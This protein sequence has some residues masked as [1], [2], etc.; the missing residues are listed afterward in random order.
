MVLK[1]K[2]IRLPRVLVDLGPCVEIHLESGKV[3]RPGRKSIHL[4]SNE[5]GRI[6][7][8]IAVTREYRDKKP[9]SRLY[10]VFKHRGV[11][12]YREGKMREVSKLVRLGRVNAVVYGWSQREERIHRWRKK[13]TA[14]TDKANDP[15]F[16]KISGGRIRVTSRGILG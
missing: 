11:S 8:V 6:L 7:Y 10:E 3:W 9:A 12:G 15:T 2:K 4:C 1:R 14:W 16:V 5:S 13:P